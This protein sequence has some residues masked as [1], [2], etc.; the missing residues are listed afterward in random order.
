VASGFESPFENKPESIE[1]AASVNVRAAAA[2]AFVRQIRQTCG[3][4]DSLLIQAA[5]IL[6]QPPA[7]F[8]SL[9]HDAQKA[10][11]ALDAG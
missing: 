10:C 11:P 9:E 5:R 6:R 7:R 2:H 4:S 3:K 8:K 1:Q